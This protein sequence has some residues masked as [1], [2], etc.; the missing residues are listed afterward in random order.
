MTDEEYIEKVRGERIKT[1]I[2]V[3]WYQRV[4]VQEFLDE[5]VK[6]IGGGIRLVA[7]ECE[8]DSEK[9]AYLGVVA[10]GI[11]DVIVGYNEDGSTKISTHHMD[12]VLEGLLAIDDDAGSEAIRNLLKAS[13]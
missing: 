9:R 6:R 1:R 5:Q 7:E 4:D 13:W 3:R 12:G 10:E 8:N 2:P 11:A